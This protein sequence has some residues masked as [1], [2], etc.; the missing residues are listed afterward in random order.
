M[1]RVFLSK[2]FLMLVAVG[3]VVPLH[4]AEPKSFPLWK[5][6]APGALGSEAK[7]QPQGIL[8]G[9]DSKEKKPGLVICP[10]G[11]Y[12]GL[13][14]DH[15]GHQIARWANSM[16]MVALICDYRHRGKGYGHPCPLQDAQRAIRFMR[17]Q[18]TEWNVDP[19]RIGIIG[20]SAGGH[21]VSTVLTH[22]DDGDAS[23]VDPVAKRSSRPNFGILC[24][25]VIGMG[26][27][28]THLGSQKNLLGDAPDPEL[29]RSLSNEYHVSEATPPT[30]LFHTQE[31][32]VVL[33]INS[34]KFYGALVEKGVLSELHVFPKGRHG[35][36]L[37]K[38]MAGAEHWPML[39]E[40]W[41]KSIKMLP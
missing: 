21:L 6:G 11:G 13:A 9:L 35:V 16:G 39:C 1:S 29:V 36:G 14:M 40:Q 28:Y 19:E 20:F 32:K 23:S 7:D 12:G 33:P 15:E 25:P 3:G 24:Y 5:D 34:L 17:N 10:G 41:L 8:Y 31:D 2:C 37:A 38:G 22:F 18:A 26:Q 4:A 27:P 30:F